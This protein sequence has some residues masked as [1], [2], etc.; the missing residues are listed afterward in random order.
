MPSAPA[1]DLLLTGANIP[2]APN[3]TEQT[4]LA[5]SNGKI[6]ALGVPESAK[7]AE[8]ISLK[9]LTILPGV[10]D[11][12]VHFREP[13]FPEK[14]TLA[15]GSRAAALGGIVGFFEMPNTSPA[16]VSAEALAE[17][18]NRAHGRSY[19]DYAFYVGAAPE[20]LSKLET[21]EKIRGC[22]G[23]KI[24][25]GS[26]TGTLLVP[27][28]ESLGQALRHSRR[29]VAV[30]A[31]D[32]PRLKER[33]HLAEQE[34]TS[35]H[36]HPLWRDPESA[37]LA[38]ERLLRMAVALRRKAH[39]LH[40][41]TADELPLIQ[42]A[43]AQ[44][45]HI[46]AEVTPQHLTLAAPE[47]YDTL[48]TLAQM[49]PPIRDESHRA[50]LW[51]GVQDGTLDII[52]SD[53]APHTISEKQGDYPNTPSGMPG[54]QTLLPLM[55][56]HVAAGRL[57]LWRLTEMTAI[58][59]ARLFGLV[60]L[61]AI[62]VKNRRADLTIVDTKRQE[63]I[64]SDWLAYR[65]GWSP[66]VGRKVTGWPVM[67]FLRGEVLLRDGAVPDAPPGQPLDFEEATEDPP[68]L[69]S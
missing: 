41:S 45:K 29:R 8:V 11:T 27:D 66:F 18:L 61:G 44:F 63:T 6:A 14:E 56:D 54:V 67:S 55:L 26:S 9:G 22:A 2:L 58:N 48:G 38:T 37:R 53:H 64:S 65:C 60:G 68:D 3:R 1:Y 69:I 23:V 47:C 21:L 20:N 17:K 32:E 35:V 34:G 4:T 15:D 62:T 24:F 30:H 16:T 33:R 43:K 49:N 28:D 39:I 25:M 46:S 19:T 52:G 36:N 5:I 50:A 51:Q 42:Q 40:L 10:L 12:Q 57:S 59:P 7:A 31:E 13:G